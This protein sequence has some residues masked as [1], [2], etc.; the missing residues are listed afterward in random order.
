MPGTADALTKTLSDIVA[1]A[2]GCEVVLDGELS[3]GDA[4]DHGPT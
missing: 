2:I 4:G 3:L 1:G